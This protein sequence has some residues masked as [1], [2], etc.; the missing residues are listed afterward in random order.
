[1]DVSTDDRPAKSGAIAIGHLAD[2][3]EQSS[4]DH[5]FMQYSISVALEQ[6]GCATWPPAMVDIA[7][8][9]EP[10][11]AATDRPLA[12]RVEP[13][14]AT[15]TRLRMPFMSHH[16]SPRRST[17]HEQRNSRFHTWPPIFA[18]TKGIKWTSQGSQS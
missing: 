10:I 17:A 13:A 14:S 1:M 4:V 12:S 15:T 11:V 5:P 18:Q 8:P 3:A 2:Q 6:G 16:P 7:D 9:A